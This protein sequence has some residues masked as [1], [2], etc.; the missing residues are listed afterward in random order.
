MRFG[1]IRA[2][3]LA[4]AVLAAMPASAQAAWIA[5]DP[6][7]APG[8]ND[9]DFGL[10]EICFPFL[11]GASLEE[12]A[13]RQKVKFKKDKNGGMYTVD[14]TVIVTVSTIDSGLRMCSAQVVIGDTQA[15]FQTVKA[16]LMTYPSTLSVA[17]TQKAS[18]GLYVCSPAGAETTTAEV[19]GLQYGRKPEG[20]M[21]TMMHGANR[22]PRCDNEIAG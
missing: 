21:V 4:L 2:A 1:L 22:P 15:H 12:V 14:K 5:A 19:V 17:K 16:R 9:I 10:S 20:I 6:K 8:E 18:G 13:K 3:G 11:T 7:R